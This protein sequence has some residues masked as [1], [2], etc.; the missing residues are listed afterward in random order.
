MLQTDLGTAKGEQFEG[1][2]YVGL[3][4][5]QSLFNLTGELGKDGIIR[6]RDVQ[7]KPVPEESRN[8]VDSSQAAISIV[9]DGNH[10]GKR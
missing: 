2:W 1:K 8:E 6:L 9:S 5:V 4:D 3:A 7:A 10:G